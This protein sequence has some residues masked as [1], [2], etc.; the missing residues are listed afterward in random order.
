MN[1]KNA[2]SPLING[3]ST[4]TFPMVGAMNDVNRKGL[5]YFANCQLYQYT[6]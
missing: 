4:T 3:L 5:T 1:L 2:K 6:K